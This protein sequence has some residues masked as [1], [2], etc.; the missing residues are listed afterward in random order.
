MTSITSSC[1]NC[2][3]TRVAA[4]ALKFNISERTIEKKEHLLPTL[5]LCHSDGTDWCSRLRACFQRVGFFRFYSHFA[6]VWCWISSAASV[7]VSQ[8][9]MARLPVLCWN[10]CAV[11][12]VLVCRFPK[13]GLKQDLPAVRYAAAALMLMICMETDR[14]VRFGR[15]EKNGKVH[16]C[17]IV[18][19]S[20]SITWVLYCVF[21]G[22]WQ[23]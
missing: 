16:L 20:I 22:H 8:W 5:H 2:L 14:V 21:V 12:E 18:E 15:S 9:K 6:L 13:H 7:I 10:D 1:T 23:Y 4:S 19:E 17:N 11:K 3:C